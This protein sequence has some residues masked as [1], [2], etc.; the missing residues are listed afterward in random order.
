MKEVTLE[1]FNE[2]LEKYMLGEFEVDYSDEGISYQDYYDN[3]HIRL[4]A[5][6]SYY[7]KGTKHFYVSG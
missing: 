5:S 3:E 7:S 6:V 2:Y 4:M 1:E